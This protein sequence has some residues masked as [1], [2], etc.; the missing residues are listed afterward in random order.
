[1]LATIFVAL[2]NKEWKNEYQEDLKKLFAIDITDKE[3]QEIIDICQK[4]QEL[5]KPLFCKSLATITKEAIVTG[6]DIVLHCSAD[7][8]EM[9]AVYRAAEVYQRIN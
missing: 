2:Q 3:G 4:E 5:I 6:C 9:E 8:Q 1:M 7:L